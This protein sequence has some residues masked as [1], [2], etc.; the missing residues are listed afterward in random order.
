LL[1]QLTGGSAKSCKTHYD[2]M[3]HAKKLPQ[4]K[5]SGQVQ[6]AQATTTKRA[7]VQVEQQLCWHN[8][9]ECVW[10]EHRQVNQP[11]DEY[12]TL[13]P[14]FQ[15]NLDEK[16]VLGCNGNLRIVGSAE[17]KKHK[18]TMQDNH[19]SVTIVCIG[20]ASGKTGPWIFLLRGKKELE[21]NH[22]LRN[23][24]CNFPGV[25]AGSKVIMTPNAYMTDEAWIKLTPFIANGI[26][27]IM[28]IKDHPDWMICMTLD[29]FG[30]HL[31]P[32][33]LQPFTDAKIEVVEEEGDMLQVNQAYDQSVA[34]E[35]KK[36]IGDTLD[37]C[38][39]NCKLAILN[40]GT[41][42][43]ACIHALRKVK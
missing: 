2:W 9:I 30:S 29:G 36:L 14:H 42:V 12:A 23:S 4:L 5:N 15:L 34:K 1:V 35:D 19:D 38:R 32:E 40:Q 39:S 31:V 10:E 41:I 27:N 6:Y 25:L 26:R 17:M 33:A 16:S 3:I 7:C 43:S 18:K 22:P 37:T 24:E 20:S 8:T 21:K 28:V 13:Q 11:S